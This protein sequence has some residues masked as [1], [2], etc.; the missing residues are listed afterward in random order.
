MITNLN[1]TPNFRKPTDIKIPSNLDV[2]FSID[3]HLTTSMKPAA[4]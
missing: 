2:T 1:I 4:D 3:K